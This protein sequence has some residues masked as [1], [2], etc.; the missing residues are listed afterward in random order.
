MS[1]LHKVRLLLQLLCF[2]AIVVLAYLIFRTSKLKSVEKPKVLSESEIV[3][4]NSLLVRR[5][6]KHYDQVNLTTSVVYESMANESINCYFSQKDVMLD[7]SETEFPKPN[8]IYFVETSCDSEKNGK[9]VIDTNHACAIESA[10]LTNVNYNVYLLYLSPGQIKDSGTLSD[11]LLKILGKY[12]NV[13]ILHLDFQKL[14]VS[15]SIVH[16]YQKTPYSYDAMRAVIKFLI[17]KK[18]GGIYLDNDVFV[19]K[20]FDTLPLNFIGT[21]ISDSISSSVIS[22]RDKN[23]T[24]TIDVHESIVKETLEDMVCNNNKSK[25]DNFEIFN[26]VFWSKTYGSVY[27][28]KGFA[29]KSTWKTYPCT[30]R[31]NGKSFET[32]E[33]ALL[34]CKLLLDHTDSSSC[35]LTDS[36]NGSGE[37]SRER[38]GNQ[39]SDYEYYH[40]EDVDDIPDIN[41]YSISKTLTPLP[42]TS[43]LSSATED[44]VGN[45]VTSAAA[46]LDI[47][48]LFV[49]QCKCN[50]T[51]DALLN[52][53]S[54]VQNAI[55][56]NR[57]LIEQ[58]ITQM[59]REW[60]TIKIQVMNFNGQQK[61]QI[62]PLNSVFDE[63]LP[64]TSI[65]DITICSELLEEGEKEK[66]FIS[67]LSMIGGKDAKTVLNNIIK[68]CFTVEAQR[69]CN[70]SGANTKFKLK[71][72]KLILIV[73]K[74]VC[75]NKLC[76]KVE[77]ENMLKYIFQHTYDRVKSEKKSVPS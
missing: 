54:K 60:D 37:K 73:I 30:I 28:R 23:S 45:N 51:K 56:Y 35:A 24:N 71:D 41:D 22:W 31:C 19:I 27:A 57:R 49:P 74:F 39:H 13:K 2:V 53:I 14:S 64:L 9:I 4:I 65:E 63:L 58:F 5:K 61:Q 3:F 76:T 10:A 59:K 32:F 70:W 6:T 77:A 46:G 21:N 33:E 69:L 52:E 42:K 11:N 75:H 7:I 55:D 26:K 29:P 48:D 18:Y 50:E 44:P 16:L 66:L 62:D 67:K 1:Y 40:D 43:V 72:T 38:S 25:C 8:S 17:L 20:S 68:H 47:T 12:P 15:M 36:D 34:K